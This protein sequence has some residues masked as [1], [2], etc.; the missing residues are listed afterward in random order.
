MM[1]DIYRVSMALLSPGRYLG[2]AFDL[3]FW[4]GSALWIFVYLLG[5]TSGELRVYMLMLLLL[6]YFLE[7]IILG[8]SLRLSLRSTFLSAGRVLG[9]IIERVASL[10]DLL[11]NV[12]VA[13]YRWIYRLVIN[14]LRRLF[15][16]LLLPISYM[17]RAARSMRDRWRL[18]WQGDEPREM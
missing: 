14:P 7:Q 15:F 4:F 11:L 6:G 18:W 12:I 5:V 9:Y 10:L 17:K 2:A 16:Y 3:I 1:I 13:P 8:R